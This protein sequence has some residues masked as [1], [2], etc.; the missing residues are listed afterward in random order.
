M[1]TNATESAE[2]RGIVD[3]VLESDFPFGGRLFGPR[4]GYI[5]FLKSIRNQRDRDLIERHRS[6]LRAILGS[7]HSWLAMRD[8][9]AWRRSRDSGALAWLNKNNS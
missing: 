6:K 7:Y 3:E 8:R 5:S 2:I 9:P 1:N 4:E